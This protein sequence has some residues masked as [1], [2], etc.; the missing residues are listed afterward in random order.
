[1]KSSHVREESKAAILARYEDQPKNRRSVWT[2][3]VRRYGG[4]HK[5]VMPVALARL[6]VLAGCPSGGVVYDPFL[7]A[8]TTALAALQLGRHFAGSELLPG[9]VRE[10]EARIARETGWSL[11]P[12]LG[13]VPGHIGGLDPAEAAG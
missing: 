3:P 10:A 2:I 8:G 1:M 11:R 12:A 9:S 6:C 13:I 4:A 7:G 5:A